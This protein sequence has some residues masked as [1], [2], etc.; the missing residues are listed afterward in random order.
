MQVNP[1]NHETASDAQMRP[2]DDPQHVHAHTPPRAGECAGPMD[3]VQPVE[4]DRDL[5]DVDLPRRNDIN[6][7]VR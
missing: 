4:G 1:G 5:D 3:H 6:D 7:L 2:V